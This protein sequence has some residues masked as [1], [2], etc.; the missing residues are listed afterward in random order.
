MHQ[1]QLIFV[2]LVTFSYGGARCFFRGILCIRL[3]PLD[4][5]CILS[6]TLD[7]ESG[8]RL[9]PAF[10][11]ADIT[12]TSGV[13]CCSAGSIWLRPRLFFCDACIRV[14]RRQLKQPHD[15][16]R[17]SVA[18]ESQ[19]TLVQKYATSPLR[20]FIGMFFHN[21]ICG[22]RQNQE[23]HVTGVQNLLFTHG[24]PSTNISGCGKTTRKSSQGDLQILG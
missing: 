18:Y 15:K 8:C 11:A 2:L 12:P 14:G 3:L 21:V 19:W 24:E 6:E 9:S 5:C 13:A 1:I 22:Q 16:R 20:M 23:Q 17:V 4:A 10:L 7:F